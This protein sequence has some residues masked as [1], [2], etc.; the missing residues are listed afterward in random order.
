MRC[1]VSHQLKLQ[2]ENGL[3]EKL[4]EQGS[5]SQNFLWIDKVQRHTFARSL[6]F[7][8]QVF[9]LTCLPEILEEVTGV[10]PKC[11]K[12]KSCTED[13]SAC[14][15][16]ASAFVFTATATCRRKPLLHASRSW[17]LCI[18]FFP[19]LKRYRESNTTASI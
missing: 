1:I 12:P 2:T 18:G 6:H 3:Q 13:P 8:C 17:K 4:R 9:S 5:Q 15:F 11:D 19:Q 7:A 16:A 14:A 10:L